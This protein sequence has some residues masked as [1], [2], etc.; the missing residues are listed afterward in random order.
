MNKDRLKLGLFFFIG[1]MVMFIALFFLNAGDF[2]DLTGREAVEEKAGPAPMEVITD[3]ELA[4]NS[5]DIESLT[6]DELV[7]AYV[8]EHGRLPSYYITK[9]QARNKGWDASEG[10]LCEVLPGQAIGGDIFSNREKKLPIENTY[11]EADVNYNCGRRGPARIVFTKK[12]EVWLSKDH[13]KTFQ[14]Q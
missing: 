13:Y 2:R 8:K 14:K 11:L 3:K 1:A 10:N 12:G 7:I 4:V 5:A 9:S 6:R